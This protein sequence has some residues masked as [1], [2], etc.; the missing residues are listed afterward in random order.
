MLRDVDVAGCRPMK[1]IGVSRTRLDSV[2]LREN[3]AL[4]LADVLAYNSSIFV[5]DY[6]VRLCRP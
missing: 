1:E 3:V 2:A 6:G 5:K 4:S